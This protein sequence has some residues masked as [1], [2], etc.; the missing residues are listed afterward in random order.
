MRGRWLL[1]AAAAGAALAVGA[2]TLILTSGHRDGGPAGILF[3]VGV[4]LVFVASGLVALWRRP[5][6]RTGVLLAGVGYLWF[7]GALSGSDNDW[8]L[9]VGVALGTVAFGTFVHL[10]LAFPWGRLDRRRDH[11]LV[12]TTYFLALGS[13]IGLLLV[14]RRPVDGC[15]TCEST[16]AIA[17]SPTAQTAVELAF[18]AAAL[19]V[20]TALLWIVGNRFRLASPALRRVLAPILAA[21]GLAV[22]VLGI[23]LV[24]AAFGTT[25]VV[26]DYGFLAA[27]ALVPIAF[28][29]GILRARLA[30]SAV[31]D[32]V[33]AL[34]EGAPLRD[35]LAQALHDPTLEVVYWLPTRGIFVWHDGNE[36][37]DEGGPR[38]ARY[39]QRNGQR[40]GAILHDPSLDDEPELIDAVAAA[41]ALW[42]DN[43]R[44]QAELRAQL[45]FLETIV[46]TA[47]SLLLS[48]EPDGRIANLNL[49]C[50]YAAGADDEEEVR[51]RHFW[52]VFIAPE[53]RDEVRAE[54]AAAAPEFAPLTLERTFTNARGDQRTIAWSTAPLHDEDGRVK[55][56]V[57]GGLDVTIR[58]RRELELEVE[59]DFASTVANTIPAL[60]AVV[61]ENAV[62]DTP[63]NRAFERILG[64]A[65]EEVV[66]R[67]LLELIDEPDEYRA[68]MAI[69]S[70]ANGVPAAERES[71]WRCADGS[72]RCVAWSAR[73]IL[74]LDGRI[75]VLVSGTDITERKRQ[76]AEVRASR[77]RIVEAADTARRKLERNLHDG[78]QQR[79]VALSVTLRLAQSKV[80]RDP[81]AAEAILE[82][83]RE[84]LALA[85]DELRELARGIHPAIL[86]DRGLT[87]ALDAL[88]ARSPVP[89]EV[90]AE[91]DGLPPAVEAAAS[92][93]VAESLA[94]VAK[95]AEASRVSV[96]IGR[97]DGHALVEVE[98]DGR[99][100]ADP[101][102]GTGLRGL[103]D[104]VEAL[105]GVLA[106]DS[107]PGGGT[108]VR[109][110]LPVVV[111]SDA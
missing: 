24:A 81:A 89:V 73:Q 83:A 44:L 101:G 19:L 13:S 78:A 76:E 1:A 6:N 29:A 63:P 20:V 53:E 86:T 48:L 70:A 40:I 69:A 66:G 8:V 52:D 58:R 91:A 77:S 104:R 99:G 38:T 39:V 21:G 96:R 97:D 41:A 22:L 111:H 75:G 72:K 37:H 93:V 79:L 26:L 23:R 95:Y 56:I 62:L 102:V 33:L 100:G 7:A 110:E 35:A 12:A 36:F 84:E 64:W 94:N 92:Y 32:L 17:D 25:H 51:W 30:R 71:T 15:R 43:E 105:D 34:G 108:V 98:D 49:A 67:N 54:L 18:T 45:G 27:F 59:R 55:N 5:E 88:A 31:G 82:G 9:T 2:A 85:L 65:P 90:A 46:D 80:G 16:I 4:G 87:A 57:C 42:L 74:R 106:V 68:L 14:D 109:A 3:A 61:D 47:P 103:A 10:L 11:L 28:L 107:P 60:L 50:R